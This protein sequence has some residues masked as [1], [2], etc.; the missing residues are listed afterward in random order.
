[1][2]IINNKYEIQK[3]LGKGNFGIVYSGINTRTFNPIAIKMEYTHTDAPRILKH[4]AAILNHLYRSGCRTTPL[5]YWFG[6]YNSFSCLV[7]PLYECSLDVYI[8]KNPEIPIDKIMGKC[9]DMMESIHTRLVVHRDIKPQNFMVDSNN[10]LYLIDFGFAT[11]YTNENKQPITGPPTKEHIIGTAKYISYNVHN[12]YHHVRRDDLLSIG[13]MYLYLKLGKLPW[14][15]LTDIEIDSMDG[16]FPETHIHHYKN[17]L[18]KYKKR[19][20]YMEP[21][22]KTIGEPI[23]RYMDYCYHLSMA[24]TP[25]YSALKELFDV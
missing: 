15:V 24:S 2:T 5:V 21:Y 20:E 13:Y 25:S 18:I 12:G 14:N 10:C 9:I 16:V 23:Y 11:F 1:M 17:R 7:M 22:C 8:Q 19:W 4:E 3:Q 6:L